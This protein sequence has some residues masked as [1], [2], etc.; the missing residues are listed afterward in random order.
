MNFLSLRD[1]IR[2]L[3]SGGGDD[4]LDSLSSEERSLLLSVLD[5]IQKTGKSP[6]LD[7]LWMSDFKERPVSIDRFLEDNYYLGQVGKS[8]YPIW[9]KELRIVCDPINNIF[10]WIIRGSIG[11]GKT[12]IAIIM[13]IYRIYWLLCLKNPQDY[14]GLIKGSPIIFALF[15]IFK[16]LAKGT[17]YKYLTGWIG[18]SPFFKER[19]LEGELK[20]SEMIEFRNNISIALGS[21]AVHAL[22]QNIIGGLPLAGETCIRLANGADIPIWRLAYSS[23]YDKFTVFGLTNSRDLSFSEATAFKSGTNIQLY[24][25]K[26]SNNN[27]VRCAREHQWMLRD[28][29]YKETSDLKQGDSL[30]P[31][32]Y[33]LHTFYDIE[34]IFVDRVKLTQDYEDVYCL[35]VPSTSNYAISAGVFHH[36]CDEADMGKSKSISDADLSQVAAMYA[37]VRSRMDS[38]FIQKGGYNP[39]ILAL[40]SQVKG[41]SFLDDHV[42]KVSSD[43]RT[44]LTSY[45]L[46]VLKSD[47]FDLTKMFK[48][49]VGNQQQ[50]SFIIQNE[51]DFKAAQAKSLKIIDV[52]EELRPR[53][54]YDLDEAIQNIAGIATY[55]TNLFLPRRDRL[56]KCYD[57][58]TPRL[59]PFDVDVV[60]LSIEDGDESSIIDVFDRT[61]CMNQFDKVSGRWT[62]RFFPGSERAIHIDLAVNRDCAGIA[63]GT[64]GDLK[65]VVRFDTE[66]KP[67]T[68]RAYNIFIDFALKIKA[69]KGSEIDFSKIRQF[70]FFLDSIGYPIRWIGCD[71]FQ[72]VDTLQIM[73][74]AKFE[75]KLIS[76][77]KN[78]TGYSYLRS[79]IMELRFDMYRYEPFVKEVTKL[80]DHTLTKHKPPIDHPP[81]G[82]KDVADAIGGVV[83]RLTEEISILHAEIK[84]AYIDNLSNVVSAIDPSTPETKRS[85]E[86][87]KLAGVSVKKHNPLADLFKR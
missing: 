31:F 60:T 12:S 40:V 87:S 63:M 33:P 52:P 24:R 75:T 19:G 54:T 9:R 50:R 1:N 5:D 15:N 26:L 8:V 51:D 28:G 66:G 21:Q 13:L 44:R 3:L 22:G 29:S 10:E 77:D 59:H 38:R 6:V 2:H 18:L 47:R 46:W 48:V 82:S 74:K 56:Y 42:K 61:K 49:V 35:N 76:M 85:E 23:L 41:R 58:A 30:M 16:Y 80:E 57:L 45:P 64:I 17:S 14:Y 71:G 36:N 43:P 78:A 55:G 34:E 53:F 62:P 83:T 69:A 67:Y 72:S 20:K 73:K 81:K 7:S 86:L 79:C 4:F 39:G 37:E 84:D 11:G 65:D 70:I 68:T 25:V 32:Y 27:S